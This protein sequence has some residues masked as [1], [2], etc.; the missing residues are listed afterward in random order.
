MIIF[1]IDFENSVSILESLSYKK[2]QSRYYLNCT[3]TYYCIYVH[4][5]TIREIGNPRI[6]GDCKPIGSEGISGR[7]DGTCYI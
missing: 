2:S 3:Q 1:A 6:D 5:G 7:H 4:Q